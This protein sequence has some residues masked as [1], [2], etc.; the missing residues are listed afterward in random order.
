MRGMISL[1]ESPFMDEPGTNAII[2]QWLGI[3]ISI[4]LYVL[5]ACHPVIAI[6]C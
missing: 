5:G 2:K 6:L 3:H 4:L 1:R